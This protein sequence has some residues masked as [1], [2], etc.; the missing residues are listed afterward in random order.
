MPKFCAD[1]RYS[2]KLYQVSQPDTGTAV[3]FVE[4][5]VKKVLTLYLHIHSRMLKPAPIMS[6][7]WHY[8]EAAMICSSDRPDISL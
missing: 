3:T 5:E 6:T 7:R 1:A 4:G 8:T 2:V